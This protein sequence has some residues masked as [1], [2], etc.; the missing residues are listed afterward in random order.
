MIKH[1]VDRYPYEDHEVS[2]DPKQQA[3]ILGQL[4]RQCGLLGE[5]E[6]RRDELAGRLELVC[7]QARP[8]EEANCI[9]DRSFESDIACRLDKN[10]DRINSLVLLM[11]DLF[12]RLE[13]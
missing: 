13:L 2:V 10:N 11:A 12:D 4:D 3:P 8:A 7:R 5:L 1:E 6:R 9:P